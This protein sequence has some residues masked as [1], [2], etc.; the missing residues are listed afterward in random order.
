MSTKYSRCW[1]MQVFRWRPAGASSS[2]RA[3]TSSVMCFSP[4]KS[5]LSWTGI[6]RPLTQSSRKTCP[7]TFLLRFMKSVPQLHQ[8]LQ[9][10]RLSCKKTSYRHGTTS[11]QTALG[12]LVAQDSSYWTYC[13]RTSGR[14]QSLTFLYG[15][16]GLLDR[17]EPSIEAGRVQS[18]QMGEHR[19]LL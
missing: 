16:L 8:T 7:N 3:W 4:G 6:L 1:R 15:L 13:P 14:Q 10:N 19:L 5:L 17:H 2:I 18:N 9:P 12:I 11:R